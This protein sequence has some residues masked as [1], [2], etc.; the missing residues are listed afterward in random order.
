[1]LN[2]RSSGVMMSLLISF[3]RGWVVSYPS[4][5]RLGSCGLPSVEDVVMLGVS[6]TVSP[7]DVV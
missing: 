3:G 2:L 5:N 1:M 6:T 4:S 7:V